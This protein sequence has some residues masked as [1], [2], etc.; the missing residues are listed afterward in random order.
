MGAGPG[1]PMSCGTCGEGSCGMGIG[2]LRIRWLAAAASRARPLEG[3]E[4]MG[5]RGRVVGSGLRPSPT[6]T[7]W[8]EAPD[9]TVKM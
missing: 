9:A 7:V 1:L 8:L 2:G 6:K 3:D 4:K 5:S